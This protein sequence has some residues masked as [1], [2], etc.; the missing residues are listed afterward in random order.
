MSAFVAGLKV[1]PRNGLLMSNLGK[2]VIDAGDL[3]LAEELIRTGTN[4]SPTHSGA[5][6]NLGKFLVK[7]QRFQDAEEVYIY[8]LYII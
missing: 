5:Y 3:S 7:Q 6:L 4:V 1:N 8:I 2:E